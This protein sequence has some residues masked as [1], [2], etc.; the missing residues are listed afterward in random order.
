ME[1]HAIMDRAG[2]PMDAHRLFLKESKDLKLSLK[3]RQ[4]L[5][6]KTL[7]LVT[8]SIRR[9]QLSKLQV[10]TTSS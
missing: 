9:Q 7:L 5:F 1:L 8:R 6:T 4:V 3:D 10:Y 2:S